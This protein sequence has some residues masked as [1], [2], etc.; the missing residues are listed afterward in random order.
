MAL[1]CRWCL[2]LEAMFFMKVN[3]VLVRL[4]ACL[5]ACLTGCAALLG[6]AS[7]EQGDRSEASVVC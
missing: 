2:L 5:F 4:W 3:Q 6:A 1:R 7:S